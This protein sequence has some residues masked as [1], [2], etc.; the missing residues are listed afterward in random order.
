MIDGGW[1]T[2]FVAVSEMVAVVIVA[3]L[4]FGCD[5]PGGSGREEAERH[6]EKV[7]S[8]GPMSGPRVSASIALAQ[9]YSRTDRAGGAVEV[10]ESMPESGER[11]VEARSLDARARAARPAGTMKIVSATDELEALADGACAGG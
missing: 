8:G 4:L 1:G 9:F 3:G 2:R 6:F 5:D 11:V 10:L 7:V